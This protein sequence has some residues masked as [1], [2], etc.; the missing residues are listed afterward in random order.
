MKVGWI[1]FPRILKDEAA[2]DE[3]DVLEE[4]QGEKEKGHRTRKQTPGVT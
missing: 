4:I 2:E 1:P 3:T